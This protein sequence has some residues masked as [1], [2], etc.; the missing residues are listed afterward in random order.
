MKKRAD[1]LAP[2]GVYCGACPSLGKTCLG[3]ASENK[4]QKRISKW[5]CKVRVCCYETQKKNYCCQCPQYPCKI[6][7]K[8]LIES[9]PSD[10]RFQYRHEIVDNF[11]KMQS[12][13][14]S[15]YLMYQKKKWAC[16]DCGGIVYF[17]Y[18]QCSKCG[19]EITP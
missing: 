11:K 5:Q 8:K 4:N 1:E 17:Y 14:I 10:I 19:K 9:H 6:L 18:Y 13:T 16:P 7:N 12:M 15:Q 3:C 2:C